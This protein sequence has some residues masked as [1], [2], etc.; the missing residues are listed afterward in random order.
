M[1]YDLDARRS[2]IESEEGWRSNVARIPFIK[3]DPT[4][5]VKVTPPYGGCLARFQVKLPSGQIKSVYLDFFD[6]CGCVGQPYWEVYPYRGD[7]GRAL[8]DEVDLLI[9]M[10]R[11]EEP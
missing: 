1:N 7:C 9:Q 2:L 8:M 6:R 3:F 4:W 5:E 11:N 10:I